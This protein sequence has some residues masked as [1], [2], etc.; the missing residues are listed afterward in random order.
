MFLEYLFCP[1]VIPLF[2]AACTDIFNPIFYSTLNIT[3]IDCYMQVSTLYYYF[4]Q[5]DYGI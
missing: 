5:Y 1:I 2:I 3:M 4:S